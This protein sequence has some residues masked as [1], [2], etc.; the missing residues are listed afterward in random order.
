MVLGTAEFMEQAR[1]VATGDEREQPGLKALRVR[2]TFEDVVKAVEKEKRET[3]EQFRDRHGD[4]GRD[5]VLVVARHKCGM[6]QKKIGEAAGDLRTV[7]VNIAIRHTV[8]RLS[9]HVFQQP[10]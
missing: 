3:W 1:R 6:T 7:A 2:I 4:W 8:N 5:M 10:L 9:R